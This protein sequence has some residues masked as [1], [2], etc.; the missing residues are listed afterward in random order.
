M[1]TTLNV[2]Y[3]SISGNTRAFAKRLVALSQV[4]HAKNAA[5]PLINAVEY[6]EQ[7]DT[8]IMDQPYFIMVPTY[9]DGGDGIDNGYTEVLTLDFRD[10]LDAGNTENL[11]G[12]IGSG[13]RNFNAQFGLTAKHYARRYNSPLIGLYELR[14]NDEEA[15]KIYAVM[16]K[17]QLD[18]DQRGVKR[19]LV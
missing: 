13:N 2:F 6:D 9:L 5:N 18:Y 3:V 12:I 17:Y 15:H 11:L 16:Q 14:G 10:E 8:S 4:E 7:A 19:A 1:S